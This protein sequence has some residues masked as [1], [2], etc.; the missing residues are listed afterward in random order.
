MSPQINHELPVN[1]KGCEDA[2]LFMLEQP[3]LQ[4]QDS[5]VVNALRKA[6]HLY[7]APQTEWLGVTSPLF[8][9]SKLLSLSKSDPK[10]SKR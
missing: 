8:M 3:D 9:K 6:I 4:F 10:L 2:L 5:D 1:N 7:E